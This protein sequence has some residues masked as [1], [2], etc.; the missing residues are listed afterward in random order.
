[1]AGLL[2]LILIS[3]SSVEGV[4]LTTEAIANWDGLG[5]F[6]AGRGVMAE[7]VARGEYQ[8]TKLSCG[9]KTQKNLPMSG[10]HIK[11]ISDTALLSSKNPATP[12]AGFFMSEANSL[13]APP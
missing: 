13:L 11:E 3:P 6:C 8:Q 5:R 4:A 7:N 12:I 2:L 1:M 10:E 9:V